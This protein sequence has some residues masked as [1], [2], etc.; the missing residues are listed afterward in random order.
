MIQKLGLGVVT[1]LMSV[2]SYAGMWQLVNTQYDGVKVY[3]T[4]QLQGTTI[5]KTML[6][7]GI[8]QSFIYE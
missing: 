5:Q 6:G 2:C 4:Y 1:L 7:Q 8:C 3:C